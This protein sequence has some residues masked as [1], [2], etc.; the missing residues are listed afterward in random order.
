MTSDYKEHLEALSPEG[1]L[2]PLKTGKPSVTG[3][4][5]SFQKAPE[6]TRATQWGLLR[7]GAPPAGEEQRAFPI[8]HLI[9]H[10]GD[11]SPPGSSVH[12]ILSA[13]ILEGVVMPFC[14]GSSPPRDRTRVACGSCFA[15]GFFTAEPPRKP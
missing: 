1:K 15:G 10:L 13:S 3:Y 5:R 12:G 8:T 9:F 4:S 14:K 7:R 6:V 2:F 11:Y